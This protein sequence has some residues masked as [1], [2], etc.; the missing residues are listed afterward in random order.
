MERKNLVSKAFL[1][2]FS[3]LSGSVFLKSARDKIR[4]YITLPV[5][6]VIHIWGIVMLFF[7]LTNSLAVAATRTWTLAGGGVWNAGNWG[8]TMPANGDDLV[9]NMTANG[10]ITSVPSIILNSISIGG[11]ANVIFTS[12]GG[13]TITINNTDATSAL[14]IIAG[15]TLTFGG[16]A[17]F[18]LFQQ[19][20]QYLVH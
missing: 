9:I 11:S 15:R 5:K 14:S 8:G 12:A 6:K 16:G 17:A 10:T 13:S 18:R 20:R 2:F 4:A 19:Q 1:I 3:L 7:L